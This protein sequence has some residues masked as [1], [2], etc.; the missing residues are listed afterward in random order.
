MNVKA[1]LRRKRGIPDAGRGGNKGI[2]HLYISDPHGF[3]A[4]AANA[5]KVNRKY[6]HA[7][8]MRSREMVEEIDRKVKSAMGK[9]V[10]YL[11]WMFALT[12]VIVV[13]LGVSRGPEPQNTVYPSDLRTDQYWNEEA[14]LR[15]QIDRNL[16][17]T[18]DLLVRL[19]EEM[20]RTNYNPEKLLAEI[21]AKRQELRVLT[22][23]LVEIRRLAAVS[24]LREKPDDWSSWNEG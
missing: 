10:E 21:K 9:M 16:R 8:F 11:P 20:D 13:V 12:M 19:T 15:I 18:R 6:V 7:L 2:V 1:M 14:R 23:Q 22:D 24:L 17:E 5:D 3:K 4:G